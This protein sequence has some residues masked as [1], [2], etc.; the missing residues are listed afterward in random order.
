MMSSKSAERLST[1]TCRWVVHCSQIWF[2]SFSAANRP[3]F[4]W[5]TFS[6]VQEIIALGLGDSAEILEFL[7]RSSSIFTAES[8]ARY[9]SRVA[10]VASAG[11]WGVERWTDMV[12]ARWPSVP[13]DL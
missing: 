13:S 11:A 9:R 8:R 12:M 3:H 7:S 1:I 4:L 5:R 10:A 2:S 6:L